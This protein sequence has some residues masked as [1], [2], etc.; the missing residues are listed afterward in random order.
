MNVFSYEDPV[1]GSVAHN[2]GVRVQFDDQSRVVYRLSGTGTDAATLRVYLEQ[3][4]RDATNQGADA[5]EYND[6][7]G[8]FAN[9]IAQIREVSGL[10]QPSVKT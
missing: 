7:L 9:H 2:Q 5:I 1:D 4:E 10:S 8:E 3:I 6:V